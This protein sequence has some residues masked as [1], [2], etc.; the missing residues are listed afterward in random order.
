M[1]N[2]KRKNGEGSAETYGT[3]ELLQKEVKH[4]KERT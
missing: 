2:K 4:A 1:K 3:H